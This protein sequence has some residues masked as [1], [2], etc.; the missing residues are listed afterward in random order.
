MFIYFFTSTFYPVDFAIKQLC[1]V[2]FTPKF[3]T[4][5]SV[6]NLQ[7]TIRKIWTDVRHVYGTINKVI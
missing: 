5:L 6:K 2:A 3:L 4:I 1:D 7:I